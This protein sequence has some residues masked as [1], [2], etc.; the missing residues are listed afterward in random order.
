MEKVLPRGWGWGIELGEPARAGATRKN[1]RDGPAVVFSASL[2]LARPTSCCRP[3][4]LKLVD[5]IVTAIVILVL[6]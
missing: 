2:F 6:E 5:I 4:L 1:A 3:S